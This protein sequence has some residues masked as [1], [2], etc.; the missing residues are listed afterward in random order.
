MKTQS[1]GNLFLLVMFTAVTI[2]LFC[3]GIPD[4]CAIATVS[5]FFLFFGWAKFFNDKDELKPYRTSSGV[6]LMAKS[7]E[8]ANKLDA[9]FQAKYKDWYDNLEKRV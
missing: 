9:E 6:V 3:T 4:L 1:S 2:L 7:Q 8:E 5:S